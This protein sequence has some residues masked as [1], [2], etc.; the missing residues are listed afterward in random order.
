MAW[1]ERSEA[2]AGG[3]PP[4]RRPRVP[5]QREL[6]LFVHR[7]RTGREDRRNPSPDSVARA[8]GLAGYHF[9]HERALAMS[10]EAPIPIIPNLEGGQAVQRPGIACRREESPQRITEHR[11]GRAVLS[12]STDY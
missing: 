1:P 7:K 4:D 2:T 11:V 5:E 3:G 12:G 6:W 10:V 9:D 8:P